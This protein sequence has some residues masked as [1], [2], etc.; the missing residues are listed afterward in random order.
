MKVNSGI[1]EIKKIISCFSLNAM[2]KMIQRA[3]FLII[4]LLTGINIQAQKIAVKTDLAPKKI[5]IGDWIKYKIE[6]SYSKE[7]NISWPSIPDSFGFFE[8]ISRSAID[9]IVSADMIKRTQEITFS[10]YD[11]GKMVFPPIPVFYRKKGDTN[12]HHILTDS[13]VVSVDFVKLDT[14]KTIKPIKAPL[15]MPVSF[16]ELVPYLVILGIIELIVFLI[17]YYNRKKRNKPVLVRQRP[18]LPPHIIALEKLKNLEEQKL[19]QNG[20]IKKYHIELTD[21]TREYMEY[22][23]NFAAMESTTDEIMVEIGKHLSDSRLLTDLRNFL[24]TSDLVKFAK[25]TPLPDENE[26]CLKTSYELVRKSSLPQNEQEE[27]TLN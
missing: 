13:F 21:I 8:V 14:S 4:V 11:S 6:V 22:R 1:K 16:R 10:C 27:G 19:W 15:K 25:M 9:S 17:F 3:L 24:E 26:K 5:L 2:R 18:S 12:I 23:F 7:L 20:E